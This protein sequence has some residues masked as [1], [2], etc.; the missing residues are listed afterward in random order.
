[1]YEIHH[2]EDFYQSASSF[3]AFRFSR[4][5][6][7]NQVHGSGNAAGNAKNGPASSRR[8]LGTVANGSAE[9]GAKCRDGLESMLGVK[10]EAVT[11]GSDI[12][13]GFGHGKHSCPGRFF[14]AHE[15]KLM[16][17]HLVQ[18]YDVEYM[19]ERPMQQTIMETKLPSSS[20]CIRVRFRG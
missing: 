17:A 3:D 15:M 13:L 7:I 9:A 6:M 14:A 2:D 5:Y 18:H 12:F 4:P 19:E 11:T 1:M 20:T 10:Q 16:L 8:L